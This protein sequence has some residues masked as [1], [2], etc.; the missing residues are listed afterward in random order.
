MPNVTFTEVPAFS[1]NSNSSPTNLCVFFVEPRVT[2]KI[3]CVVFVERTPT[4]LTFQITAS[5][6][7]GN[8]QEPRFFNAPVSAESSQ[9]LDSFRVGN[10][11]ASARVGALID[12]D[13]DS[14]SI[15][16]IEGWPQQIATLGVFTAPD[17][18]TECA[19][20]FEVCDPTA[21]ED[22][23]IGG[24]AVCVERFDR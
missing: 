15:Q 23:K 14:H 2:Y 10:G 9:Q 11:V 17:G 18:A 21:S 1:V 6:A 3:S 12:A 7:S 5:V 4:V 24:V 22:T 16:I 13:P 8:T 20:N 19:L